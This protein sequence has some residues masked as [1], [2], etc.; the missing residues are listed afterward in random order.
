MLKLLL[1]EDER[2]NRITLK[3]LLEHAGHAVTAVEDGTAGLEA[4]QNETWDVVLTDYRLPGA[5][6]IEI[7]EEVKRVS[8]DTQVL[9]MTAFATVEN[10][11]SALKKGAFDYLTK[12]F[13][14]DELFHLLAR[15]MAVK[16]LSSENELLRASLAELK[17]SPD[18]IGQSDIMR[19]LFDKV[20]IV[21]E[22]EH[23]VLIQGASGTGKEKIANAVQS[24]SQRREHPYVKINCSALSE[25][26]FE[27]EMF[28]HEKGAFTGAVKRSIGRFE[29]AKG[30]TILLDDIDDLSLRLQTKLLR[31]IQEGEIERVGGTEVIRVDVRIIAATKVDLKSLVE[32]K[33]FR[34]DLYYRLN[35]IKL[36]V[37]TLNERK[38]DIPLL[39]HF[40]L[41]KLSADKQLSPDLIKYLIDLDWPGNV[42]E[43]EHVIMQMSVFSR[44]LVI[45]LEDIPDSYLSV[46]G[47]YDSQDN[48]KASL[49]QK[50]NEYELQIINET[51]D[52]YQGNQQKVA[53]SLGIP[54]TT[55]RSKL[56]KHGLI[57]LKD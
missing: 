34:E 56:L 31:V 32:N 8:P 30:G 37:P 35:V 52:Q 16:A 21:A 20:K 51:M 22:S 15:I 11:L 1:V 7:L 26:L 5:D 44:K 9:I 46:Q 53:D 49:T 45:D 42:R 13:D 17:V 48:G 19:D 43:L 12:P 40:F 25:T 4:V 2:I 14:P 10:A 33:S 24:L 28:G 38:S 27:T 41:S 36:I 23:T 54:R 57:D 18:L 55:L 29:R 50:V 6:G 3:K 47:D 39:A